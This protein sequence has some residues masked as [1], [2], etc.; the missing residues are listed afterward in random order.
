MSSEKIIGP[1]NFDEKA[2]SWK[3]YKK[4]IEVWASLTN[5]P[6]KKQGPALWM[7][8]SGKAKEVVQDMDLDEIK[9]DD[10]LRKM[11]GKLDA[12]FKIDDNQAA[13]LAYRSFE[14]FVRPVDMKMQE[15]VIKFESLNNKIKK[16]DM[17]LPDGV[18]AYRFLHSANLKEDEMK[19]CRATIT[20]F[21]YNDMKQKVLSLHGDRVNIL[22]K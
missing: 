5:L 14:T 15:F 7:S 1:P 11:L 10:G 8:L 13:Y 19:L 6:K 4:E 22:W 2:F 16:H 21:T 17:T 12:V 9:A 3:E 20:D 18:L